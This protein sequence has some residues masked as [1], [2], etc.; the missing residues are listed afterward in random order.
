MKTIERGEGRESRGERRGE[1]ERRER[2]GE[3]QPQRTKQKNEATS[4]PAL[5]SFH[6]KRNKRIK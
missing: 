1:R 3:S 2:R 6:V 5:S 4:R